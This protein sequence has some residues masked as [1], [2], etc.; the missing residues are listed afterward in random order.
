MLLIMLDRA[1]P[2][3]DIIDIIGTS[4]QPMHQSTLYELDM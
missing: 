2:A 3:Q 1:V 4:R